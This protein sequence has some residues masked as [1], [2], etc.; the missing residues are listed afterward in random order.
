MGGA[1]YYRYPRIADPL[2]F[3]ETPLPGLIEVEATPQTDPRGS[4]ARAF[5]IDTFAE[6][7]LD[8]V[9]VQTN[10]ST[11][12]AY[13]L[14]GL[15]YQS[16]PF[17]ERKLVR[18]VSGRAYDVAV[19]L[20]RGPTFGK[21][22]AVEL[23]ADKMNAVFIPEG[24]AHGF[25]ALE[26]NTTLLYQMSPAYTAGHAAGIRWNDPDIA[27]AWPGEPQIMSDADKKFPLLA[28]FEA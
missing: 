17:G 19:D 20:R 2:K 25:L 3:V 6:A 16:A 26:P 13:T 1:V 9:P 21:W 28:Q 15:H 22:H 11:N 5:C 7:G 4:F 27:I 23:C 14:R 24:F 8:F 12:G 10:L 18:A